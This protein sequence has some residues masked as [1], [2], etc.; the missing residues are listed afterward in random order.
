MHPIL[1]NILAIIVGWLGGS[2][3]NMGLVKLNILLVSP[4]EGHDMSTMEGLAAAMPFMGVQHMILPFLAHALGTLVGAFIAT[5]MA[6]SAPK[7]CALFIG[8]FFLLGGVMMTQMVPQ[9]M[10]FT[11]VDLLLA[12]IPMAVIGYKLAG[13][14]RIEQQI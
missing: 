11:A 2:A 3:V 6:G 14:D 4:P 5:K 7:F 8:F 9:P 1:K 13:G 12:Y 10:W